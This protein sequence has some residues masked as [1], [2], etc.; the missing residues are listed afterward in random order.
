MIF[1]LKISGVSNIYHKNMKTE[2]LMAVTKIVIS[3]IILNVN[4][5]YG[6]MPGGDGNYQMEVVSKVD[7]RE[8]KC[9]GKFCQIMIC[10]TLKSP[11]KWCGMRNVHVSVIILVWFCWVN[12][13]ET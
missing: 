8:V 4:F 1:Y 5:N 10:G 3:L 13:Q 12:G 9:L 2:H 6:Q 7:S 11:V